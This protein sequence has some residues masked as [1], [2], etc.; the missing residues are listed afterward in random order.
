M[1]SRNKARRM[2]MCISVLAYTSFLIAS[3]FVLVLVAG[4]HFAAQQEEGGLLVR[5]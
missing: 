3:L 1:D 5:V 4:L 2:L